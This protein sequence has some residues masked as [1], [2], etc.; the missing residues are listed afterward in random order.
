MKRTLAILALAP[1]LFA[2]A[3]CGSSSS[4]GG[5]SSNSSSSTQTSAA[6]S[7]VL[8]V[9]NKQGFGRVL[10]DDQGFVLYKY[11]PDTPGK[12][13]CFGECIK[14]W[15]PATVKGSGPLSAAGITGRITTFTR[16][17]GVKQLVFNGTPLYRFVHDK[18]PSQVNGQGY[19]HIWFVIPAK[20]A[21]TSGSGGSAKPAAATSTTKSSGGYGY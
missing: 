9:E 13:N 3:A 17:D 21:G 5:S 18:T 6:P 15:P 7:P 1:V 14:F 16:P 12:S 4:S 19:Q 11:T 20:K 10:V 8:K 2:V